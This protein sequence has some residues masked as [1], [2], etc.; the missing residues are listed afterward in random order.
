MPTEPRQIPLDI[1]LNASFTF[2]NF[3]HK[4]N[5]IDTVRDL[6]K[7]PDILILHGMAAAGKTHLLQA[8]CNNLPSGDFI[9]IPGKKFARLDP[10]L[11]AVAYKYICIDD[12]DYLLGD[13]EREK[14]LF[15]IYN[16]TVD[17]NSC[18]LL[19][20]LPGKL[21]STL[22]DLESRLGKTRTINL[23]LLDDTG[24][25][26]AFLLKAQSLGI[27][28]DKKIINFI[29]THYSRNLHKMMYLLDQLEKYSLRYKRKITVPVVKQVMGQTNPN[30]H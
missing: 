18:L 12:F 28:V 27:N 16:Q 20:S 21:T 13:T 29:Q 23:E 7:T 9:Y 24:K 30:T 17:A 15:D 19:S 26:K 22:P 25:A 6:I 8:F 4:K 10:G 1:R 5:I 11:L 3:Y 14:L 2:D